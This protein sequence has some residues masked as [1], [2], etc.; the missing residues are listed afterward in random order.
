MTNQERMLNF[1]NSLLFA[2]PLARAENGI[3]T[4]DMVGEEHLS[5]ED[6]TRIE[7]VFWPVSQRR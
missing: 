5:P 3:L 4:I 1:V 2:M 6:L 7:R